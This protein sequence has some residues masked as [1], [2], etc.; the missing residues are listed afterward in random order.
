VFKYNTNDTFNLPVVASMNL[1]YTKKGAPNA[2]INQ[3]RLSQSPAQLKKQK[4][5]A[6]CRAHP[7]KPSLHEILPIFSVG[8][9]LASIKSLFLFLVSNISDY[10]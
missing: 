2:T 10:F 1:P 9:I 5:H 6:L 3:M 4:G 7:P 8:R